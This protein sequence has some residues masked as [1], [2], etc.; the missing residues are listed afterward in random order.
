MKSYKIDL[1]TDGEDQI[2]PLSDELLMEAGWNIGDTIKFTR[3]TDGSMTMKKVDMT[4]PEEYYL[5]ECIQQY[6][7]R[8]MVKAKNAEHA[9]DTV[10]MNEASEFS[11]KD[12]GETIISTRVISGKEEILKMCDEENDYT[13][14]WSDDTKFKAFV[15]EGRY[16]KIKGN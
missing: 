6:R 11:Q 7:T 13:R 4:G 15:T 3:N 2:L 5:V 12:L 9:M 16:E 14:S 1:I 8:Y 10:T